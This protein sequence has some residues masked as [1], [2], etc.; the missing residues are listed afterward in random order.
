MPLPQAHSRPNKYRAKPVTLDGMRF[1]S[2]AEAKRWSELRIKQMAGMISELKR[3]VTMPLT[4]NGV[5]CGVYTADFSYVEKGELVI[6]ESKGY[7]DTASKLRI[8]IVEALYGIK[9][10]ITGAA[11]KRKRAGRVK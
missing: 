6:E 2:K 1:A 9:V 3:Q 8:K 4:I 5:D 11:A 10:R 7:F